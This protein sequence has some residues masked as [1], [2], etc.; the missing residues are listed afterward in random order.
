MGECPVKGVPAALK[1]SPD[2]LIGKGIR[3]PSPLMAVRI[4]DFQSNR[5]HVTARNS[6]Q[7]GEQLPFVVAVAN[8][9]REGY[10]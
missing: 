3:E 4:M 1:S 9:W 8:V 6:Q 5:G 10:C 2:L 7:P